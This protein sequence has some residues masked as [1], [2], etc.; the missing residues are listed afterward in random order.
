MESRDIS[1][2]SKLG[3][4]G[5]GEVWHVSWG[6]REFAQKILLTDD[7][8]DIA[9]FAREVRLLQRLDHPNIVKVSRI[10]L[11]K[12]PYY[13]LMPI[14]RGSLFD[15]FPGIVGAEE[16]IRNIFGSVLDAVE[17]LHSQGVHHRDLKLEN[18]LMNGD[19]DIVVSDFG[20]GVQPSS[21]TPRLTRTGD[22]LGT[23]IYQS[24]EQQRDAKSV[25]A[26]TDVFA[27]GKI[28]YE[29][30]SG[31]LTNASHDYSKLPPGISLIV[32]RATKSLPEERFAS[33]AEMKVAFQGVFSAIDVE[34]NQ[35]RA[36]DFAASFAAS[37]VAENNELYEFCECMS[38][39]E[40]EVDVIHDVLMM[41]PG[42]VLKGLTSQNLAFSRVLIR[43]FC[44]HVVGLDW[45]FD[46]VDKIGAVCDEFY[47]AVTDHEIRADLVLATMQLGV[48]HNRWAVM[49]TA[50]GML[51]TAINITEA[52]FFS[53]RIKDH[54]YTIS[55]MRSYVKPSSLLKPLRELFE[56]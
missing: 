17:Y 26:R 10:S 46:F 27:L 4:G 35:R 7:D 48:G 38:Q 1:R 56:E 16:R 36:L 18:V 32:E 20:L 39:L 8:E 50:S 29:L 31:P 21:L 45:G 30:Y 51:K 41:I 24:P 52:Q 55:R 15:E 22:R 34:S 19:S 11:T 47:N 6:S 12:A 37:G 44:D 40:S 5:Y 3:A 33:A 43:K 42:E 28:L 25:D 9:R 2:I 14:Y 49:E 23:P 13:Y 54:V 53:E